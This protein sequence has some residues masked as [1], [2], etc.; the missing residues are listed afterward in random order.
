[1]NAFFPP[2]FEPAERREISAAAAASGDPLLASAALAAET[3]SQR[4]ELSAL[5][6][7]RLA[8]AVPRTQ[9]QIPFVFSREFGEAEVAAVARALEASL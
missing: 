6:A 9:V 4:A 1:L 3:Y 8:A 7:D 2:R 5:Y